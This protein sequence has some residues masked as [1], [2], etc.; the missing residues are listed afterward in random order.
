MSALIL[1]SSRRARLNRGLCLLHAALAFVALFPSVPVVDLGTPEPLW[2][3]GNATACGARLCTEV[4]YA[5][6]TFLRRV[7]VPV[8]C[9]LFFAVT[10]AAHGLYAARADAYHAMVQRGNMWWRWAEYACSVPL[11]LTIICIL[12]G[13]TLDYPLVQAAALGSVTQFFGLAAE[14]EAKE[15]CRAGAQLAHG[16]GY[17]P[18]LVAFMPV[19]VSLGNLDD[20]PSFVPFLIASQLLFF[21]SFGFVQLWFVAGAQTQREYAMADTVYLLLSA[22]CK[23]TLAGSVVAASIALEARE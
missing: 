17:P 1:D 8:T 5:D 12:N 7:S 11:M 9:S 4:N 15:G 19:F 3:E 14:H 13:L 21:S 2:L 10:A 6:P 20:A 22:A 23:A 16:L 18:L